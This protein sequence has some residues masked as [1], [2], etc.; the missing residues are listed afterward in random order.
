MINTLSGD[1]A[2]VVNSVSDNKVWFGRDRIGVRPLYGFTKDGNFA[3]ASY[4]RA[5][6]DF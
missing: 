6:Q 4:A 1:F 5:L 2:L 3:V